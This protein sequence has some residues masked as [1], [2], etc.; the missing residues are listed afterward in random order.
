MARRNTLLRI[1]V[2]YSI[3]RLRGFGPRG[4]ALSS[5]PISLSLSFKSPAA[6][7]SAAWSALEAFGIANTQGMRVRKLSA[8]WRGLAL[9]ASAIVCST[10]PSL[11]SGDGG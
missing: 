11:L 4:N 3:G 9:C 10:S 6:A 8:T 1:V 2:C 5:A 7:F